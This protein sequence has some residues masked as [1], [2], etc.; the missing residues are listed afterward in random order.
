M[1]LIWF[2]PN[3]FWCGQLLVLSVKTLT[4]G[5][6][7]VHR[8][9]SYNTL[10]RQDSWQKPTLEQCLF[11]VLLSCEQDLTV[12]S[13]SRSQHPWWS[14]QGVMA[15]ESTTQQFNIRFP[16]ECDES[17][18]PTRNLTEWNGCARTHTFHGLLYVYT[19]VPAPFQRTYP[20]CFLRRK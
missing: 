11:S 6:S 18:L 13:V 3:L 10:R 12:N 1:S 16:R 15:D 17:S 19:G 7:S 4:T 8:Y 20:R 9:A 5:G 14:T 2:V